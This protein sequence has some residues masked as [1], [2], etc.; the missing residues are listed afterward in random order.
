MEKGLGGIKIKKD[1]DTVQTILVQMSGDSR[2][3]VLHG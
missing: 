3:Q 1:I 2:K